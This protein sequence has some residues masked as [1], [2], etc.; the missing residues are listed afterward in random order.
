MEKAESPAR[1]QQWTPEP[2]P[3]DDNTDVMTEILDALAQVTGKNLAF[4]RPRKQF[5][6]LLHPA[7]NATT[8]ARAC[9]ACGPA[10]R[11]HELGTVVAGCDGVVM[12]PVKERK[13]FTISTNCAGQ[14]YESRFLYLAVDHPIR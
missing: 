12:K 10:E 7:R 9:T 1:P 14:D 4:L 8:S 2:E 5:Q 6:L 13:Q 3:V 11:G